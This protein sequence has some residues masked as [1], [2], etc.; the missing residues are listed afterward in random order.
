MIYN[1]SNELAL[2]REEMKAPDV[3]E[4]GLQ[5]LEGLFED[6][7]DMTDAEFRE[8]MEGCDL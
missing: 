2:L 7:S 5:I 4:A 8:F 3:T 6:F 1:R